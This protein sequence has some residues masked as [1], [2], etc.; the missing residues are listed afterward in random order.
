M[1]IPLAS[2]DIDQL[3]T[4]LAMMVVA[5]EKVQNG[6]VNYFSYPYDHKM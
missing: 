4:L 2:S 5:D 6:N 3:M 1:M